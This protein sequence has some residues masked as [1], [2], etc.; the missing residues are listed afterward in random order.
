MSI[1]IPLTAGIEIQ[2]SYTQSQ[3][4]ITQT[5]EL[6]GITN[7]FARDTVTIS[8]QALKKQ[9]QEAQANASRDIEELANEIIRV[10]STIG[11]ARSV[12]NLTSSQATVLYHKIAKLIS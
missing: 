3:H 9:Q 1:A 5:K 7:S 4:P 8:Q 6:E 10:N 12:G 2:K 11:R